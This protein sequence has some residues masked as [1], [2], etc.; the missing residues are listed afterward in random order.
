M[1]W[2]IEFET[3]Y[4]LKSND[5]ID[6]MLIRACIAAH[7]AMAV[8]LEPGEYDITPTEGDF[9]A[10][11]IIR[12]HDDGTAT[13][14]SIPRYSNRFTLEHELSTDESLEGFAPPDMVKMQ[15]PDQEQI[16]LLGHGDANFPNAMQVYCIVYYIEIDP[17]ILG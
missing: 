4:Q 2:K 15:I 10:N 3:P 7:I 16:I 6:T 11:H 8:Q 13:H 12:V 9:S 1:I 14:Y 17:P 5:V